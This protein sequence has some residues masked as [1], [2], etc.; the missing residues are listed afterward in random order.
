M[1]SWVDTLKIM[2]LC[3]IGFIF[4]LISMRLFIA[5]KII[6]KITK[7]RHSIQNSKLF[8]NQNKEAAAVEL[9]NMLNIN[10]EAVHNSLSINE[11]T[12]VRK[13]AP[14]PLQAPY[15]NKNAIQKYIPEPSAPH[16]SNTN[17]L[18]KISPSHQDKSDPHK[19]LG[20]H[21]VC[22]YVVGQGMVWEDLCRCDENDKTA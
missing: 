17:M 18:N 15:T 4:F 2:A 14:L 21:T 9:E 22:S 8:K 13:Y 10:P 5:C 19:C 20:P 11:P 1:F 3:T 7:V 16:S 12:F 6:P